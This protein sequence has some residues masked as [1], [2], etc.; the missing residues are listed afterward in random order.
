[1]KKTI[2]IS[3]SRG[4]L[5]RNILRTGILEKLI[6]D[7][8]FKIVI[9]VSVAI[10]DYFREE[11]NHSNIIIE[12]VEEKHYGP[13][14]ALLNIFFNGLV[15]TETEHR[16]IKYG[17]ANKKAN[18]IMIFWIKNIVFK[19]TSKV[20]ILK[21]LARW[22]EGNLFQDNDYDYLFKKYQPDIVFCSSL[23]SKIDP[24]LIKAAKRFKVLSISMPKSWDTVG[25]LFFRVIADKII[26]NNDF[27]KNWVAKEQLV[28]KENIYVCGMPQFD[29]YKNKKQYLTK[30]EF[31]RQTNLDPN[32]PIILYASE[33]L[34]THWD[35][36]YVDDLINNCNILDKYNLILRPHF[37]NLHQKLYHKFKKYSHIYIDDENLRITNMFSDRWDPTIADMEWLAEIINASDVVVTFMTTFVLDVFTLSKP[38]INIFYDLPES[39]NLPNNYPVIPLKELYNCFHYNAVLNENAVA[40][41]Y[42]GAD[43][44]AWIEKY[45]ANPRLLYNER[46]R[47]VDKLCYKIDGNSAKRITDVILSFK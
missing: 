1:M 4:S 44:I 33:G 23:Y 6:A 9:I 3:I 14:R 45:L 47:V 7:D 39:H 15:Y 2:F 31:C 24:I 34:W 25:R 18:P 27:M 36:V 38:V 10:H 37:S 43:V 13:I 16:K 20:K 11:F 30:N 17:G 29:V 21:Y 12:K 28:K 22:V 46:Q 8:N 42:G 19:S 26:L 32:K 5:A 40:R 35:E 41:A